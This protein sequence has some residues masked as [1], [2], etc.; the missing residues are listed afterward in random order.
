MKGP[1]RE[2]PEKGKEK[3]DWDPPLLLTSSTEDPGLPPTP[4]LSLCC[5]FHLTS[6]CSH[7]PLPGPHLGGSELVPHEDVGDKDDDGDDDWQGSP[8]VHTGRIQ[9]LDDPESPQ[10][11]SSA[12]LYAGPQRLLPPEELDDTH[13]TQ[14]L[15]HELG[16]GTREQ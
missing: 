4:L 12:G 16:T 9:V 13:A 8:Q 2:L 1:F 6:S 11:S 15:C 14:Q 7:P 3:A 5:C 10:L